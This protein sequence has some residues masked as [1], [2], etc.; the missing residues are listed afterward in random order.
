M[1]KLLVWVGL[2]AALTGLAWADGQ[3][4][5]V[6]PLLPLQWFGAEVESVARRLVL[7]PGD[8][9]DGR[10]FGLQA[11]DLRRAPRLRERLAELGVVR[12]R[13]ALLEVQL[14]AL[15]PAGDGFD[16]SLVFELWRPAGGSPVLL[17]G[18]A[19]YADVA[20][21]VRRGAWRLPPEPPRD[22][23]RRAPLARGVLRSVD[24]LARCPCIGRAPAITNGRPGLARARARVTSGLWRHDLDPLVR[25]LAAARSVWVGHG[26]VTLCALDGS[27][28]LVATLE[29]QT[30][31]AERTEIELSKLR[32]YR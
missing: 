32:R 29:V 24:A 7:A 14:C 30:W 21:R 10:R 31:D 18:S 20:A 1:V 16:A 4:E 8:P 15:G 28:R 12:L 27:G 3:P 22:W 6:H 9:I 17:A 2:G 26:A 11:D 5:D 13:A 19:A 23:R 25:R